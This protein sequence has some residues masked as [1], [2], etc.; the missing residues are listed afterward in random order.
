MNCTHREVLVVVL[1]DDVLRL[2]LVEAEASVL[3]LHK[4][5]AALEELPQ[6]PGV[7]LLHRPLD[8]G[9]HDPGKDGSMIIL[10]VS[11]S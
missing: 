9:Q 6:H 2:G 3:P 11:T 4:V 1:R 10:C 8:L 5:L 7:H